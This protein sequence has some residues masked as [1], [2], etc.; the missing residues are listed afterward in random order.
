MISLVSPALPYAALLSHIVFVFLLL[1]VLF[2]DSWGGNITRSLG[3][4]ALPLSF[5]A[6]VSA[7]AGSLFYSEIMGFEPCVLCWWQR[8]FLYPLAVVF[9]TALWKK[10]DNAF[11]YATPLALIAAL[12]AAYQSYAYLGGASLLSCTAAGGACERIYVMAFGYI[13]I[14]TMS[15]TVAV[16]ILLFA[17][18]N[19][20]YENRNA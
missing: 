10:A 7:V 9:G 6:A 1:S 20:I 12:I 2:R 5:A 11:L 17:W 14:P 15:L 13:T 4:H 16:Y 19:K 18:T 8:A 3:K